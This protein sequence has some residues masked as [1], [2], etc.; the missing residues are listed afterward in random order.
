MPNF[1][2]FAQDAVCPACET[3]TQQEI[4]IRGVRRCL[5]CKKVFNLKDTIRNGRKSR[6]NSRS[7]R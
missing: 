1:K 3:Y 6:S 4:V 7:I 2:G 5:G